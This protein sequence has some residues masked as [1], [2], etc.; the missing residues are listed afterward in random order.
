MRVKRLRY[1]DLLALS[2]L[3]G[4]VLGTAAVRFFGWPVVLE[5]SGQAGLAG[6]GGMMAWKEMAG[7]FG[8]L[9]GRRFLQLAAGWMMG[10][11]VCSVPL[12]CLAA[13]CGGLSWSVT[14]SILTARKGLLG[15]PAFLGSLFPQ[16]LVYGAVW[17]VLAL[18]AGQEVK[19]VRLGAF[20]L[21]VLLTALGAWAE[22]FLNPIFSNWF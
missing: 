1:Q 10:M 3:L 11:T 17:W 12:F 9:F 15:L 14:L 6:R 13:A 5:Q 21:L 18:W 8:G 22:T 16:W 4:I 19:R 20:L 2:F 7:N